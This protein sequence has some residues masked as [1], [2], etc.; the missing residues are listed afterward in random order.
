MSRKTLLAQN[1]KHSIQKEKTRL[2]YKKQYKIEDYGVQRPALRNKLTHYL[3]NPYQ[4]EIR[5]ECIRT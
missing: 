3:R 1:Q 2:H 5:Q 4:M